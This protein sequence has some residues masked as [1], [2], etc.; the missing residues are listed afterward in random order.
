M[1]SVEGLSVKCMACAVPRQKFTLTEYAPDLVDGNTARQIENVSGFHE[2][3]I[4][5]EE[6]TTS[7]LCFE[8]ASECLVNSGNA[9]NI[10]AV[11]FLSQTPDY[12]MPAT[13]HI[14][15]SRLGL[16]S[17]TLC[18]DINEGCSGFITGLYTAGII[19]EESGGTVLLTGGDTMS[20]LTS[21]HDRASRTIFGDC[22]YAALIDAG[23]NGNFPFMFG[24]YGER[25]GVLMTDNTRHRRVPDPRNEGMLFMDGAEILKF[26]LADVTQFIRRFLD[27]TGLGVNDVT[28]FAMHQANR[29]ML[30]MTAR[31]LGVPGEIMPFTAGN[32]GNTSSASIPM[33]LCGVHGNADM[34][35]VMCVGFGVGLSAGAC[36]A[37]FS[38][39]KFFTVIEI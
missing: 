12:Y 27:E 13:S 1:Y 21:P 23:G 32:Y 36:I 3:R 19:A 30:R 35:R 11:V 4:A 2:L 14:L 34:S 29:L 33:L 25:A 17:E 16:P 37:D 9:H 39:T 6:M 8:A 24:S 31:K 5:P 18:I 22:G 38:R 28:L 20:K 7:D 10:A 26:T 15:Q